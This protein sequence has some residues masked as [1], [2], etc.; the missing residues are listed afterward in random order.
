[1]FSSASAEHWLMPYEIAYKYKCLGIHVELMKI[2]FDSEKYSYV[3]YYAALSLKIEPTDVD[4]YYWMIASM[5]RQNY[6]TM[7]KGQ[8]KMA[9]YI[10]TETEYQE[11]IK[12]LDELKSLC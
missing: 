9:Q 6:F 3:Q 11:L 2:Y 8:L 12:R 1:M 7:V 4:A 5:K 10:L